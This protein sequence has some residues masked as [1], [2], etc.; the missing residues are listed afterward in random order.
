MDKKKGRVIQVSTEDG[1]RMQDK[2]ELHFPADTTSA[3]VTASTTLSLG[4][5]VSLEDKV[6]LEE[7]IEVSKKHA[8]TKVAFSFMNLFKIEVERAPKEIVIRYQ[9]EKE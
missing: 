6:F 4:V 3:E 2:P 7:K 1:I 8:F 5:P 9:K